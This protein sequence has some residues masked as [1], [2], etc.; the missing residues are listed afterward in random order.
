MPN[1]VIYALCLL[2]AIMQVACRNTKTT[3]AKELNEAQ[4]LDRYLTDRFNISYLNYNAVVVLQVGI[5]GS[6]TK[7]SIDYITNEFNNSAC[8][9]IAILARPDKS[10]EDLLDSTYAFQRVIIDEGDMIGRYGLRLSNDAF[11]VVNDSIISQPI[12]ITE[13]NFKS[14]SASHRELACYSDGFVLE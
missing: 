12:L 14:I 6:C 2:L 3:K 10:L 13:E 4:M 8:D 9:I 1:K 5:C 11:Y 7:T